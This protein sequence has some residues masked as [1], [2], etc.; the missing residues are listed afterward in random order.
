MNTKNTINLDNNIRNSYSRFLIF[1]LLLIQSVGL[2][3]ALLSNDPV[4]TNVVIF[5]LVFILVSLLGNYFLPRITKGDETFILI[6]NML[7]SIGLIII[8]RLDQNVA[9]K[10]ILWYLIGITIFILTNLLFKYIDKF[11]KNKFWLFFAITFLTFIVTLVFGINRGGAKNWI[12]IG[13]LFTLQLSEFAKI[14]YIFM[15]AS[16]YYDYDK[17]KEMK[18][19]KYYHVIAT[20]IFCGLFF[21][22]KELGTAILFFAIM[23]FSM[24]VF[25]R[26][27]LFILLNILLALVGIYLAS[28]VLSHIKVRMDIWIDPWRDPKGRGYQIIQ[29]FF[30]IANGGFFGTGI[31]LGRPELVPVVQTDF[32]ITAIIEEMG[33]FMGFSI[34]L[35]YILMFYKSIKVSL[36]L[37]S[38]FYSSLAL[39]IGLLFSIQTLIIL[40][41]ILNL[42]P[43][44][45]ITTPF[46]SYGGSSTLSSFMLLAIIQFLS[47]RSGEI[48]GKIKK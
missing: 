11:L 3:L 4:N 13:D 29:G 37:N 14:S 8:V 22:Q 9:L 19:G 41:G 43:L 25:E 23:I 5:S 21:L 38:K 45:G 1:G 28:L 15:I 48:Y 24:F 44:T 31:G 32:I 33:I 36:Q 34:I 42:I 17:F 7:Y 10:H 27:Y 12:R 35:M 40:G 6:V 39:S 16:Y 26:R 47:M 2:L 46:L 30:A 18:F 20:Y